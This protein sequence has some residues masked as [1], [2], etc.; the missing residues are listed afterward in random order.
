MRK[1]KPPEYNAW[2]S[3]RQR[4]NNP[5]CEPYPRYGGRGIRVAPEWDDFEQFV[6]D[7]GPRPSFRHSLDRIDNNGHYEPGNVRWATKWVQ[8][9][10]RVFDSRRLPHNVYTETGGKTYLVRIRNIQ[11]ASY[12]HL[13][14]AAF[15]SVNH[16]IT[17]AQWR[18]R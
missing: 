3:M 9:R 5:R 6:K 12:P 18:E 1:G 17:H 14:Q 15:S 7:V 11:I 13:L 4:C 2:C 8:N 10:N 16:D